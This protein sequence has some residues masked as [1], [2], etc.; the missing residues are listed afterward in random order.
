MQTIESKLARIAAVIA[1]AGLTSDQ[2]RHLIHGCGGSPRR[3]RRAI[4]MGVHQ[5]L[6]DTYGAALLDAGSHV[7]A[8]HQCNALSI[9]LLGLQ[10]AGGTG[11][12]ETDDEALAAGLG[13]P[14]APVAAPAPAPV[15]AKAPAARR[16]LAHAAAPVAT[17]TKRQS[18]VFD[19]AALRSLLPA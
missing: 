4:R 16:G 12:E 9:E 19:T 13:L 18:S 3:A 10:R 8:T 14:A 1:A 2:G 15:K 11:D 6:L 17:T 7:T 5:Q